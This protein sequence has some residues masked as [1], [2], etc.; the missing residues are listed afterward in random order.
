MYADPKSF[1]FKPQWHLKEQRKR[2]WLEQ[3][4]ECALQGYN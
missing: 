1:D 2:N 4:G 3:V